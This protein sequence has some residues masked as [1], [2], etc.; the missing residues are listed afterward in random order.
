M[1]AALR[2]S[3]FR[4][5]GTHGPARATRTGIA[6]AGSARSLCKDYVADDKH[7]QAPRI[8]DLAYIAPNAVLVENVKIA[9]GASIWYNCV[10]RGD[11]GAIR[12]GK[13]TNIQ[14]GT[15]VHV[16]SPAE[17]GGES[18]DTIVGEGVTVGHMAL[19]HACVLEDH[20]FVGM[21]ACVMDGARVK[22]HGMLAAGALLT[23][24]K[25]VG[26]GELWAGSPAKK[27][28]DL[29]EAEIEAIHDSAE[30]YRN[31]GEHYREGRTKEQFGKG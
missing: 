24:G 14:D 7:I 18:V 15:I 2:R 21:M 25:V 11:V 1:M 4:R 8:D 16:A 10:L 17:E 12:I 5:G 13:N 19:L 22:T 30:R 23:P 26:S 6:P 31:L 29:T 28:R 20:S 3:L 27:K 9:E